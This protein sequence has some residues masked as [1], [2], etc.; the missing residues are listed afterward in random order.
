MTVALVTGATRGIGRCVALR[1]AAEGYEV[2]VGYGSDAE[3]ASQLAESLCAQGVRARS[4][5]GDLAD[6]ATAARLVDEVEGELGP[7]GVLVANAG[8]S[9]EPRRVEEIT[10]EEWD[11]L[12]AVNLR[13]PF[14][15]AQRALPGMLE[16]GFGRFVAISSVAASTG[17][18]V[19][20]HYASSKAGL[21]GLVHS[22]ARQGAGHGVTA[23]AIAPALVDTAMLPV[24]ATDRERIAELI[25]VG[26]LGDPAEVADLV[27]AVI[28]N[29]YLTS[30]VIGLDGGMH[31][32]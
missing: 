27:V 17:G 28:S 13:A 4:V 21:H 14:L 10:L 23:N 30:Q 20:A 26:R 6:P 2:G 1:L 8:V 22:I 29:G 32:A 11:R 9:T 31:P 12:Q 25:P 7:V 3:A 15:L 24:D 5:G 16:R 19:G 18:M